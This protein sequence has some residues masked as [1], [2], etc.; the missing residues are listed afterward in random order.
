MGVYALNQIGQCTNA[1][2][3]LLQRALQSTANAF[4]LVDKYTVANIADASVASQL[5]ID[6]RRLDI[7][8]RDDDNDHTEAW[9]LIGLA[10]AC[11]VA[12]IVLFFSKLVTC[13]QRL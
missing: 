1:S 6:V 11:A 12:A 5:G 7:E 4:C 9:V 8:K 2:I 13:P 10:I 3:G